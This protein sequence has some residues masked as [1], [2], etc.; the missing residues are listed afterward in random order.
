MLKKI[1]LLILFCSFWSCGY[2][3][4]YLE[5]NDL[6]QPIKNFALKGD[7]KVNNAIISVLGLKENKNMQ[8]GYTYQLIP[9]L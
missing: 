1:I 5:K 4:L 9:A 6:D 8:Y 3:P 7:Q 2:T